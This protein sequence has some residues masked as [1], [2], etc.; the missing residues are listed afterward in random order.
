VAK[1]KK[2]N[3]KRAPRATGPISKCISIMPDGSAEFY[4]PKKKPARKGIALVDGKFIRTVKEK[5]LM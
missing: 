4:T 5:A 1:R 3:N 2:G